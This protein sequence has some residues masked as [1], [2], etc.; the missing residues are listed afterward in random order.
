MR[1]FVAIVFFLIL[2]FPAM[3]KASSYIPNDPFYKE[4]WYQK[5]IGMEQVWGM[6]LVTSSKPIIVA[7]IDTRVDIEHADLKEAIWMNEKEIPDNGIDDDDNG[8]TDDIHGWNFVNKS[9]DVMALETSSTTLDA[10]VHGTIVS[11]LIAAKGDN[12]KGIAG[13]AWRA[14]I[15]PLVGLDEEGNGLTDRV[16]DAVDYAVR[17]GASIINMSIEGDAR[18]PVLDQAIARARVKGVLTVVAA[19]NSSIDGG[20]D[21]DTDP[22]YPTCSSM[23]ATVDLIAVAATD[24][25]D[26]RASFSD[27]GHCVSIAAPGVNIFGAEPN[28]TYSNGWNGTSLAAPLV[29]GAAALLKEAHPSWTPLQIKN[30]LMDSSVSIDALQSTEYRGKMGAGRLDVAGALEDGAVLSSFGIEATDS[31]VTTTLFIVA[32]GTRSE[33]QPFGLNDVRGIRA[34]IG[35]IDQDGQP[36][37]GVVPASGKDAE[38]VMYRS[39]GDEIARLLLGSLVD[40]ALITA[41]DGGFVVADGSGG[42][43]WGIDSD[44]MVRLF[45]PYEEHYKNGMDLLTIQ[46]QAAF[47]PR[48]GGGRLVISDVKG[49]QLVSAFPFGLEPYGRWSL[50]KMDASDGS[51]IVFSG[52]DGNKRIAVETIGQLGWDPVTFEALSLAR[53]TLSSG[54]RTENQ[55][56]QS[57]GS[58]N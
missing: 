51:Y 54:L 39:N 41:V 32:S 15:M 31:G 42:S 40:G 17:N 37:I 8:Y 11:S 43:A 4:Q 9:N 46:N 6:S 36:E 27:Y 7:V 58:W 34:A 57:Y 14:K 49:V 38:F 3:V 13:I 26:R 16:A 33:V 56:I 28:S 53:I 2:G 25:N 30:R 52:P 10:Y 12:S 44:L 5:K 48:N 35:D 20:R 55:S 47:A 1:R 29:S 22:V 50:A 24:R 23:D 45:F 21:L 18:D 19:G